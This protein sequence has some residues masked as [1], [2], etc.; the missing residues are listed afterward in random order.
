LGLALP[1][2]KAAAADLPA[3]PPVRV[4]GPPAA[5]LPKLVDVGRIARGVSNSVT[6]NVSNTAAV[7]LKTLIQAGLQ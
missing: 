7:V 2:S 6:S 5:G 3:V 4:T 1:A